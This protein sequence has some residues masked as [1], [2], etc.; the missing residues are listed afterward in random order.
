MRART[1]FLPLLLAVL[2]GAAPAAAGAASAA[3]PTDTQILSGPT[4]KYYGYV[5][6]LVVVKKGGPITY[7]N[8][9]V[10]RH[11]VVQDVNADGVHGSAKAK[12][13]KQFKKGRCPV[14][15]SPLI[16]LEQSEPVQGLNALK[17]G[18]TYTF[19]CT[20]HPGMKGKLL[21]QP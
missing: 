20:L 4:A 19:Y 15:Y 5:T 3:A 10:E 11:N 16:G 21:V 13:C 7:T 17:P 14:F 2:T 8:V 12:W 18:K 1:V 6:P 9:D